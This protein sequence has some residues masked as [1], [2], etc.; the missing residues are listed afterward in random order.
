[1]WNING[2]NAVLT[3]GNLQH[4]LDSTNPDII[5]FN[6]TKIDMEK[7]NQIS[8]PKYFP[9]QYFQFWN[10]CKIQKG[11]SGTA[12]LTKVEPINVQYDLGIEKHD[13]EGRIITAEFK[14][15]VLVTVY[16]PNSG[17]GLKRL[18]YRVK[19]WDV[20]FQNHLASLREKNKPIILS[21]DLN[22]AHNDIDIYDP[23]GKSSIACFTPEE[24]KS[25]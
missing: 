6:E 21:G 3:K 11:Y 12:L 1:M 9:K 25:F 13:G 10:C 24:R 8:L 17:D 2:V 15:F 20:D 7:I 5:C 23:N 16:V 4:F 14:E 18:E 22:V 19:E